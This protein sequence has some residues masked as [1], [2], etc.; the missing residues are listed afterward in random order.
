MDGEQIRAARML[1][2]ITAQELAE[3]AGVS[4]PTIQRMD[5]TRGMVSGRHDTVEKVRSALEAQ[6]IQFL[7]SGDTA[8]GRGVVLKARH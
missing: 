5:S 8:S 1:L 3:M 4:V 7:E 6:G 2:G